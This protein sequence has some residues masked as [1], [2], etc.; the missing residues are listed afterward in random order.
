MTDVDQWRTG[1]AITRRAVGVCAIHGWLVGW[2]TIV[3]SSALVVSAQNRTSADLG[4]F[5]YQTFQVADAV[6]PFAK[7]SL[8]ALYAIL[9]YLDHRTHGRLGPYGAPFAGVLAFVIALMLPVSY[10]P[11][12]NSHGLMWLGHIA[13]GAMGGLLGR[14]IS[15]RCKRR[16]GG[17]T[18]ESGHK[19]T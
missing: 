1:S 15:A 10:Y 14:H 2:A 8:G 11:P 6:P 9:L 16:R 5:G 12:E 18:A 19:V 17:T 13:C 3:F 7:L 4:R